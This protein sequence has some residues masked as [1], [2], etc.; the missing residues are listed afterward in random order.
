MSKIYI[1]PV[2][3]T[4]EATVYVEADN[5]ESAIEQALT[6]EWYDDWELGELDVD[7]DR[8][9]I[10]SNGVEEVDVFV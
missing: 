6:G 7:S 10:R 9:W 4:G 3:V 1:V 2:R 8:D 5:E